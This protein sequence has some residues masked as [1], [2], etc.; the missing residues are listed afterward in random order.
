MDKLISVLLCILLTTFSLAG[1]LGDSDNETSEDTDNSSNTGNNETI[2]LFEGDQAGECSDGADND[3]DGL[4]DCDDPDCAGSPTCKI[5]EENN[6]NLDE[7]DTQT[8]D[9]YSDFDDEIM[10]NLTNDMITSG[11]MDEA[12][13]NLLL[14]LQGWSA[15]SPII[16]DNLFQTN[17]ANDP[18]Y[19][20]WIA[21]YE[22][23]DGSVLLPALYDWRNGEID[24]TSEPGIYVFDDDEV[25]YLGTQ[26]S[27][28]FELGNIC[29]PSQ[30]DG[31][32]NLF[33]LIDPPF[34]WSLPIL[35]GEDVQRFNQSRNSNE[36]LCEIIILN[37][38]YTFGDGLEE[39]H[40]YALTAINRVGE[41][42]VNFWFMNSS[43]FENDV[44]TRVMEELNHF[45]GAP[46]YYIPHYSSEL[47]FIIDTF[48]TS[49]SYF[50]QNGY[51]HIGDP[52]NSEDREDV[53]HFFHEYGLHP[54]ITYDGEIIVNAS[55][56]ISY[57]NKSEYNDLEN[58][59]IDNYR[60]AMSDLVHTDSILMCLIKEDVE[61]Y[62]ITQT[63]LINNQ[64]VQGELL[65]L[66]EY[67]LGV[68]DSVT[69]SMQ[70]E[71]LLTNRT[72]IDNW[73]F[74]ISN[75]RPLAHNLEII[76]EKDLITCDFEILNPDNQ[77]YVALVTW[78]VDSNDDEILSFDY[79][80]YSNPSTNYSLNETNYASPG[81]SFVGANLSQGNHISC[82][83]EIFSPEDAISI[84]EYDSD[85]SMYEYYELWARLLSKNEVEGIIE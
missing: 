35:T 41:S 74:N 4:F 69:C 23:G 10:V 39:L 80:W 54:F 56:E 17:L 78:I 71:D 64:T 67:H 36:P 77:D 11:Y 8:G 37:S 30:R 66:N 63:W 61:Y 51:N 85:T 59:I 24:T 20:I 6:T 42:N 73:E 57:E 43:D 28:D 12:N 21:T 76:Q 38:D 68:G 72:F 83:V 18:N 13:C 60:I 79:D 5:S 16:K 70:I 48:N 15:E 26:F 40:D 14:F 44:P 1:C 58:S 82:V 45:N 2:I 32:T 3:R 81:G 53:Y 52:C 19:R 49:D 84:L 22:D 29:L 25:S 7:N 34:N 47:F 9:E 50:G 75:R 33:E 46:W 55:L 27:S 31:L 65:N 62:K